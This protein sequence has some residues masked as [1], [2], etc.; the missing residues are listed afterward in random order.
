MTKKWRK[1]CAL[2]AAAILGAMVPMS[3]MRAQ[4]ET[5][6]AEEQGLDAA[7]EQEAEDAAL[8]ADE[9]ETEDGQSAETVQG[10]ET[11]AEGEQETEGAVLPGNEIEAGGEQSTETMQKD[12]SEAADGQKT[13]TL[14]EDASEAAGEQET[15]A[16]EED[17]IQLLG[18]MDDMPVSSTLTVGIDCNGSHDLYSVEDTA[19][20]DSVEDYLK[21]LPDGT[22]I[23]VIVGG[24]SGD[25]TV[26]YYW[27]QEPQAGLSLETLQGN[28]AWQ[29]ASDN[30]VSI[31]DKTGIYVLYIKVECGGE[32]VYKRTAKLQL[33][34]SS[35]PG[36]EEPEPV[37]GI[38]V[39]GSYYLDQNTGCTL[40][41]GS[42][43]K[44]ANDDTVYLGGV[45]VYVTTS[46]EYRFE[47]AAK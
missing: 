10:D 44:V 38:S 4:A 29:T 46:G 32:T 5:V 28:T 39:A 18:L 16:S 43:W 42:N 34:D 8:T 41:T 13:E 6:A 27:D 20:G 11:E 3:T 26:Y 40:G 15:E 22:N 21:D 30:K 31:G 14:T 37:T 35:E 36:P 7:D 33:G 17:G 2:C 19:L 24:V 12:A 45:T 1:L 9:T 25:Y 23:Q 47:T